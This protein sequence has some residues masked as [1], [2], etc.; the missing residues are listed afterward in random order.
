VYPLELKIQPEGWRV[1]SARKADPAFTEFS[2]KVFRRDNHTCQFC[3]FQAREFQE[4]INLDQDYRNNKLG[5][6]VTACCFCLQCHFLNAV[7][8]NY[9]GGI[10]ISSPELTQPEINSF[11]HVIFCAIANDTGY[12]TTAQSIYRSLKFRSK[13]I[14]EIFG[15]GSHEPAVFTQ[16]LIDTK[17]MDT[18]T[19][20]VNVDKAMLS[21]LRLLPSRTKF[22]SQIERWA[23]IALEEL[24]AEV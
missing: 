22:K 4:V 15:E 6:L 2:K 1:F 21:N 10:L 7:G 20:K 18:Q 14:D 8:V 24:S 11:C 17:G 5:N 19:G 13:A 9:G 3:G 12:K 16:L 23:A